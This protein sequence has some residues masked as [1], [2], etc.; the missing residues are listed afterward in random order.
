MSVDERVSTMANGIKGL[1]ARG[2]KVLLPATGGIAVSAEDQQR[3]EAEVLACARLLGSR[4]SEWVANAMKTTWSDVTGRFHLGRHGSLIKRNA[5]PEVPLSYLYHLG[6]RFID[7]RPAVNLQPEVVHRLVAIS[8]CALALE[9]L[10]VPP[11][12]IHFAWLQD[13]PDIAVKSVMFDAAFT[14]AQA[15]PAHVA[16]FLDFLFARPEIINVTDPVTNRNARQVLAAACSL[17]ALAERN[18]PAKLV[19]VPPELAIEGMDVKGTRRLL[20]EIFAHVAGA[21]RKLGLGPRDQDIDG[22]FR[23]LLVRGKA[24][25][26]QPRP[27]A[28]RAVF[29]AAI[30]WCRS[31]WSGTGFDGQVIGPA[32]E[33]FVRDRLRARGV[34]VD[35]G[36]YTGNAVSGECDAVVQTPTTVLFIELKSKV[37]QRAGRSGDGVALLAD[38]G[39]AVVRPLSQAMG[40][41]ACMLENGKLVLGSE[42]GPVTVG[43]DGREVLKLSI[44]R[45]DMASL[46]DRPFLQQLL[47]TGCVGVF[48]AEDPSRQGDF[49]DLHKYFKKL[50]AAALATGVDLADPFPF[51]SCWSLSLFQLLLLL[52]RTADADTLVTELVRTRRLAT[53]SRDF[54]AEY[55]GMLPREASAETSTP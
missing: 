19:A 17:L 24:L 30:D 28:A 20:R 45:G 40:H 13:L 37:L 42:Q 22:A 21:N 49:K 48:G 35:H 53:V 46:H 29:N 16:M 15:K 55:A 2:F 43:L 5:Q 33:V 11:F 25:V 51:E 38:L 39:Q 34:H 50:K 31:H 47:R 52:E 14:P 32:I 54:Y 18:G 23:P 12:A 10:I 44:A 1:R 27:M 41:H 3:M 6:L 7:R 8:S 26:M 36:K 4:L 9:D